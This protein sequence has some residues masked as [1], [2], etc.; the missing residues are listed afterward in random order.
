MDSLKSYL[1]RSVSFVQEAWTE[2]G[3]VH[4]PTPRETAQATF[5][6]VILTLVMAMWL[7]LADFGTTRI[8]RWLLRS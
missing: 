8:V 6:V 7:G 3:K 4:F 2:L 1:D 5:V